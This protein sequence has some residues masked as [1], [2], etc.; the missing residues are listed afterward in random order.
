[1]N[2]T[3]LLGV[4]GIGV[5]LEILAFVLLR[6]LTKLDGKA[7]ATIIAL[8]VIGIFIPWVIINW[9]G[10]DVFAIEIGIFL[11]VA[12]VLGIIGRRAGK[13]W[14]WAPALIFGFFVIVVAVNVIF[15]TLAETG[16]TG[17]FSKLLP[18]PQTST[19]ANSRFPGTVSHDFQEKE[20]LY[21]AYLQDVREQQQRGWQVRKGWQHKP[22]VG[23]PELFMIEVRDREGMPVRGAN[24]TGEFLRPSNSDDDF[25]FELDEAAEH[26]FYEKPL[27][28]PR[29]GIWS[30][31][32]RI[33]R[34]D[35]VHE[36]RAT[37]SV[38]ARE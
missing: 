36:I 26:G 27:T 33:T 1:M 19:V 25:S 30:L 16:I 32:L 23:E 22:V 10:G 20:A 12:Y 31:V 4:I 24:V 35:D 14:H 34:G 13:S 15:V 38:S 6:F 9:P 37:T 5:A 2:T 8:G 21:N 29:P 3:G 17:I 28:M 18:E 11:V 7:M